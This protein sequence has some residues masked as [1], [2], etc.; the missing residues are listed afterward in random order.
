MKLVAVKLYRFNNIAYASLCFNQKN[1]THKLYMIFFTTVSFFYKTWEGGIGSL[2]N[3][4]LTRVEA[5]V[6]ELGEWLIRNERQ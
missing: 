4:G 5:S 2:H 3:V 1:Y 6:T